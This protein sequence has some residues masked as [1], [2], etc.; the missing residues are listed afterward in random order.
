M[1]GWQGAGGDAAV[2]VF[3]REQLSGVL[4]ATHRAGFGAH[5][6]VL[7]ASRGD[8]GGQL[9]RA[10]FVSRLDP[11]GVGP[12]STLILVTAPGRAAAAA[13]TFRRAGA[14]AIEVLRRDGSVVPLL[15][16]TVAHQ[17]PVAAGDDAA[18]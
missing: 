3:S 12:D 13:E 10:G 15:G 14:R 18:V 11:A 17:A 9:R 1:E 8:L 7:D 16:G 4:V 2:G 6:R 5:A